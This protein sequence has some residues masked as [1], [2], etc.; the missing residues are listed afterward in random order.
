MSCGQVIPMIREGVSE[1]S[2]GPGHASR[3]QAT[4]SRCSLRS[5]S[6]L[7]SVSCSF[8]KLPFSCNNVSLSLWSALRAA[9]RSFLY[10]TMAFSSSVMFSYAAHR[11]CNLFFCCFICFNSVA[12]LLISSLRCSCCAISCRSCAT[13]ASCCSS[14]ASCSCACLCSCAL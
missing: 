10:S 11:F 8:F 13:C 7:W 4:F 5:R 3:G 9:I 1:R 14:C 12:S 6:S 2:L